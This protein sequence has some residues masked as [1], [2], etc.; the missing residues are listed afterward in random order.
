MET[1]NQFLFD[2]TGQTTY[3]DIFIKSLLFITISVVLIYSLFFL[4]TKILYRKI[5][6]HRDNAIRLSLLWAFV[7]FFFIINIYFFFL[8]R[9]NGVESFLWQKP[10]FYLLLFPFMMIYLGTIIVFVILYNQSNKKLK[11]LNH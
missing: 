5:N 8:V 2:L 10:T 7:A 9:H 3:V 6:L 4:L 11:P 1:I